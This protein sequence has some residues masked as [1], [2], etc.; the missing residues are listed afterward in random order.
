MDGR[1]PR[2]ILDAVKPVGYHAWADDR[3][4]ALFILGPPGG[5]QPATLRVADT[6]SGAVREIATDI[7]RSLSRIPG[8]NKISFVQRERAGEKT[9]LTIKELDPKSGAMR[10]LIQAVDGSGDVDCAWTPGGTLLMA[11]GDRLYAWKPP[12]S[13][14]REIASLEQLG[15]RGATRLAV[16]PKSTLLAVV[17]APN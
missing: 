16:S 17:A 5:N 3:T 9:S 2:V 14:W 7:G 4:L 8:T 11:R 1:D 13:S 12:Q 15:L 10:P 6:Q